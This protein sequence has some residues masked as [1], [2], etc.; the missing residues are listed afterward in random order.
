MIAS[1]KELTCIVCA[2][3]CKAVV[4][5]TEAGL[6]VQGRLC[7]NGQDYLKGE[8]R[9]PRRVLTTT[10][11]IEGGGRLPVRTRGS[12]P[13]TSLFDCMQAIKRLRIKAPVTIGDVLAS[14]ILDTGVDLIACAN[15]KNPQALEG[16]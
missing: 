2:K 13:K 5:E 6:V 7:R 14:N 11:P 9:D 8:F 1:E 4:I 12:I 16:S 15:L 10:I 3:G